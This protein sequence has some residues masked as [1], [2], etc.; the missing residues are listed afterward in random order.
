MPRLSRIVKSGSYMYLTSITNNLGGY[1]YWLLI[2][3][4][5]GPSPLG[6]TSAIIGLASLITSAFSF[7]IG[8]PIQKF[9][10]ECIGKGDIDCR[11]T[12]F[13]TSESF[14]LTV[15]PLVSIILFALA[16]L[17]GG[18]S[19]FTP[20]MLMT[21]AIL[22]LI[23]GINQVPMAYLVA[24]LWTKTL[25]VI[26]L[27]SNSL[28]IITGTILVFYGYSWIGAITGYVIGSTITT[29][30][31]LRIALSEEGFNPM[32]KINILK[33][34]LKAGSS[35]WLPGFIVTVGQWLGVLAVFGYRTPAETGHY[36]AAYAIAMFLIAVSTVVLGVLL[37]VLSSMESGRE[38]LAA[39][40]ARLAI[41]LVTPIAVFTA[42]YPG[43]ILGLLGKSYVEASSTLSLLVLTSIPFII[44][45]TT[46]N[47]VF[48]YGKY[49]FVLLLGLS[50]ALPR[51]ALYPILT[52]TYGSFGA[53]LSVLTG[54]IIGLIF[55]IVISRIVMFQHL[56]REYVLT[57]MIP[58]LIILLLNY[59]NIPWTIGVTGV[60]ISYLVY[61]KLRILPESELL[62][63]LVALLGEERTRKFIERMHPIIKIIFNR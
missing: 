49:R 50:Q 10:G 27:I 9:I 31:T 57:L 8:S 53:A 28:K 36:Y 52:P 55:A 61:A 38:L 44:I 15:Y 45:V 4:L 22:V 62:E 2:S 20:K 11:R 47:L 48:S 6:V 40:A 29:S 43:P 51:I 33:N 26:S 60:L 37:P 25:F 39:K 58:F 24:R 17:F 34:I 41:V 1:T 63:L 30:L 14:T 3:I 23:N 59:Y 5:A 32:L 12:Y 7:G 54:A 16:Y 19:N 18:Y 56:Y 42:Y 35:V 46:S 21:A 13:W